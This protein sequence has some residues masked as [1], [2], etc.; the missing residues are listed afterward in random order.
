MIRGILWTTSTWKN[1]SGRRAS[2]WA[3]LARCPPTA[4]QTD[5]L[6]TQTLTTVSE[7]K[8]V[9]LGREWTGKKRWRRVRRYRT[10]R[11]LQPSGP[12]A[13]RPQSEAVARG[14]F[15]SQ[16]RVLQSPCGKKQGRGTPVNKWQL[17][18]AACVPVSSSL[19]WQ[20]VFYDVKAKQLTVMYTAWAHLSKYITTGMYNLQ[21]RVCWKQR[22]TFER[23]RARA[24]ATLQTSKTVSNIHSLSLL[25]LQAL[26]RLVNLIKYF[27]ILPLKEIAVC[28]VTHAA[29]SECWTLPSGLRS[30]SKACLLIVCNLHVELREEKAE[31]GSITLTCLFTLPR[32]WHTNISSTT[33]M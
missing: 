9:G 11:S 16:P 6:P 1:R 17:P 26:H 3:S 21:K 10:H 32:L 27:M 31:L 19:V 7:E 33:D 22:C 5:K 15:P 20:L 13:A 14:R 24:C 28:I 30:P 25:R 29:L 23:T 4:T 18:S 2:Q 12:G 8:W